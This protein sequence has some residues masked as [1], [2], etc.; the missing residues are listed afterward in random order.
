MKKILL[1]SHPK[2]GRKLF[3]AVWSAN[4][5]WKIIQPD[6]NHIGAEEGISPGNV[7]LL[8]RDG[9]DVLTTAYWSNQT[10][11][12]EKELRN[13]SFTEFLNCKY[14]EILGHKKKVIEKLCPIEYWVRFNQ[15]WI[16]EGNRLD[17]L[18]IIRFEDLLLNQEKTIRY[19][20]KRLPAPE[21]KTTIVDI[22]TGLYGIEKSKMFREKSNGIGKWKAIF[23]KQDLYKFNEMA[24][25]LMKKLK[26]YD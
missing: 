9:R 2:S 11:G 4:I 10:I 12:R 25:P 3:R 15:K 23:S 7:V 5:G 6:R 13:Q 21:C 17:R 26:Y 19:L 20:R 24:T 22:E 18:I 1:T 16:N 14:R 8:V